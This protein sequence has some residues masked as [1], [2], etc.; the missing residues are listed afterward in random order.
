VVLRQL[1]S[2]IVTI[3]TPPR[4]IPLS[5]IRKIAP[6]LVVATGPVAFGQANAVG[7]EPFGQITGTVTVTLGGTYGD[8][9]DWDGEEWDEF[10]LV[11]SHEVQEASPDTGIDRNGVETWVSSVQRDD[12]SFIENAESPPFWTTDGYELEF[13]LTGRDDTFMRGSATIEM[14]VELTESTR[15]VL[16]AETNGP[17]L[18]VF[19]AQFEDLVAVSSPSRSDFTTSANLADRLYRR[20]TDLPPVTYSLSIV[21]TVTDLTHQLE[22]NPFD[23]TMR[24]QFEPAAC[25]A[26]LNRD[27]TL[28]FGDIQ[29]FVTIFLDGCL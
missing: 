10:P 27:Q 2:A 7:F 17:T 18:P 15:V 28:D 16:R 23:T 12:T 13:N 8:F 20:S 14:E 6:S 9:V 3:Q 1:G 29:R 25:P 26:D 4:W 22:P 24:L 19:T 21:G 5:A 11:L